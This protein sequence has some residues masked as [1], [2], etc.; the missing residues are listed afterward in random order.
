[1]GVQV[2]SIQAGDGKHYPMKRQTVTL[3]YVGYLDREGQKKFD[4]TWD[5]G[6]HRSPALFVTFSVVLM[7]PAQSLSSGGSACTHNTNL[8]SQH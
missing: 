3:H 1:M 6:V 5:R 8:G 2:E 7:H 4:S